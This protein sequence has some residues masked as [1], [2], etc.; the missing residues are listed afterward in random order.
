MS[1]RGTRRG[2]LESDTCADLILPMLAAA[3]WESIQIVPEYAVK[4]T[5][6]VSSGGIKRELPNGRVD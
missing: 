6:V 4:G 2:P 3:G 5:R 1:F